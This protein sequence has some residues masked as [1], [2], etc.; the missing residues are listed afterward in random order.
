M[1]KIA[2]AFITLKSFVAYGLRPAVVEFNTFMD[3]FGKNY[4][5]EEYDLRFDIF[6]NNLARIEEH[7]RGNHS[8]RMGV[9]AFADLTSEEFRMRYLG[10]KRPS[11]PDIPRLT[12]YSLKNL[13]DLPKEVDWRTKDVVNPVKDQ[14][15]C[16]SCWAFSTIGSLESAWAIKTRKLYSLS[17]QQLVDCSGSY[18]NQGCNGGL[19]QDAFQYAEK[20]ALCSEDDYSYTAKDG[21]CKT[22]KGLVKV[23]S[24]VDV[25]QND[26][27]ALQAAIVLQP[28]SVAIEAD[29]DIQLYSSGIIDNPKCGENLDHGVVTLGFGTENGQE[30]YIVRNSWGS[31]WGESGY[32][33][34]AR[35]V[36]S[37]SGMCGIAM[38]PSYPVV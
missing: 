5:P 17:E 33:R 19:M 27:K 10:F 23:K 22:C 36:A 8:W 7:N 16:G 28:V 9:N 30:Y 2:L 4:S 15:Q 12:D 37:P 38:Q 11:N 3:R 6:R 35:N 20:N 34:L 24:Y 21:T 25:P 29:T 26:E 13:K 1:F 14:G 31:S 32:F 18:G